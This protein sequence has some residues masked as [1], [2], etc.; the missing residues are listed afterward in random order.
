MSIRSDSSM[1]SLLKDPIAM[2]Q[3]SL[4]NTLVSGESS[5]DVTEG[6]TSK[7]CL[8]SRRLRSK[9]GSIKP[10]LGFPA[11]WAE[12]IGSLKTSFKITRTR[13]SRKLVG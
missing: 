10:A 12:I 7:A 5:R 9:M 3:Q 11:V 4:A 1:D 6:A 2:G 13:K 8:T